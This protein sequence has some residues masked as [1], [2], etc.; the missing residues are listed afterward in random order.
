MLSAIQRRTSFISQSS[1]W[2]NRMSQ[3]SYSVFSIFDLFS[4][5]GLFLFCGFLRL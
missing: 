5:W 2:W 1:C 3:P 4:F